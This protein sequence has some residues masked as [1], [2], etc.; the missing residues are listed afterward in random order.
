MELKHRRLW[1]V[2]GWVLVA[3]TIYLSLIPNPPEPVSFPGFD[4]VEHFIIYGALMFWFGQIYTYPR[5]RVVVA[6]LLVVLGVGIEFVQGMTG[7]RSFEY[8]DMAADTIGV[9][10]GWIASRGPFANLFHR[11]EQIASAGRR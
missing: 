4:K 6:A 5:Q 7:Y 3:A 2:L 11:I 8:A 10:L 9:I 1:L